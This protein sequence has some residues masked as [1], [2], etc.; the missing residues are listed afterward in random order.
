MTERAGVLLYAWNLARG[1]SDKM[2]LV[3]GERVEFGF[4]KKSF[5]GQHDV[6][7]LDRMAFALHVTVAVRMRERFRRNIQHAVVKHIEN[8]QTRQAASRVPRARVT[9]DFEQL[10]AVLPRLARKLLVGE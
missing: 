9:D 8:V 10:A 3:A 6:K 7:R 2:R 4:G 5:V 1:M